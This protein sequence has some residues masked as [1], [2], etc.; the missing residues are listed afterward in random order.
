VTR[1]SII[2]LQDSLALLPAMA[3]AK[4]K[5]SCNANLRRLNYGD[6]CQLLLDVKLPVEIEEN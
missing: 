4:G 3:N 5:V 1:I 2:A 6:T